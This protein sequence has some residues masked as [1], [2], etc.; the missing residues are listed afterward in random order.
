M[1]L[2]KR[3]VLLGV[4]CIISGCA[5][6]QKSHEPIFLSNSF[7]NE[8]QQEVH[9]F[10]IIDAR[11]EKDK[12]LQDIIGYSGGYSNSVKSTLESKGYIVKEQNHDIRSC[13]SVAN[14]K[15]LR[16][17]ACLNG[18]ATSQLDMILLLSV[19]QYTPPKT[20]SASGLAY[21]SGVLIDVKANSII[22]KDSIRKGSDDTALLMFGAGGYLGGV[23]VKALS[24]NIIYRNDAFAS[25]RVIMQTIPGYPAQK[26]PNS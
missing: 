24:P 11:A 17:L 12:D 23:L 7:D 2:L 25:I 26:R 4:A 10:P 21:V 8:V 3:I 22:W 20:M 16:D 14:I 5:S 19:D 13:P 15:S 6:T 1:K 9:I 18:V